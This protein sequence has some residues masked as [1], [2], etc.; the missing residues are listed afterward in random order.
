MYCL[1]CG[2]E[3]EA[4]NVFCAGCLEV[5]EKYPVKP[6]TAVYIPSRKKA[7][8]DKK[9]SLPRWNVSAT[10]ELDGLR[11][12]IRLMAVLLLL[13][14]LALCVATVLL[15]VVGIPGL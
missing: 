8:E 1:K 7:V 14:T 10:D 11:R 15:L 12:V 2:K 9:K 4:D 5:M 13:T 6:G 3:T